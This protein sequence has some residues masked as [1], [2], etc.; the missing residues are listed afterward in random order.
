MLAQ[1]FVSS[2]KFESFNIIDVNHC[3]L[4]TNQN[5]VKANVCGDKQSVGASQLR[6]QV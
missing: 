2:S 4:K 3:K 6:G 1:G 5:S